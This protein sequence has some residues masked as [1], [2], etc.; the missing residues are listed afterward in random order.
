MELAKPPPELRA[1][2]T[3]E[4]DRE[5]ASHVNCIIIQSTLWTQVP[6]PE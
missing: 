4:T 5:G 1:L 2:E 3:I 6:E